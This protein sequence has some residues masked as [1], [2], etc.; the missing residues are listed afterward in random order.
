[1]NNENNQS[2]FSNVKIEDIS[3]GELNTPSKKAYIWYFAIEQGCDMYNELEDLLPEGGAVAPSDIPES[4]WAVM[5]E[6]V[7]AF[8]DG[9]RFRYFEVPTEEIQSLI[10]MHNDP[11]KHEYSSWA[12]YAKGYGKAGVEDYP[13]TD[14]FPCLSFA[15]DTDIVWDGWHRLHSYINAGHSTIPVLEC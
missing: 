3:F 13:E 1:M 6:R 5:F 12:E 8:L 10:L 2:F 4:V 9:G 11:I 14:R 7:S 15:G